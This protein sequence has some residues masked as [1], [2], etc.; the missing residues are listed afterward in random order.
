MNFNCWRTLKR[1][2]LSIYSEFT[3]N[4]GI[5]EIGSLCEGQA[6]ESIMQS[7]ERNRFSSAKEYPRC[8]LTCCLGVDSRFL[9]PTLLCTATQVLYSVFLNELM[10]ALTTI[11]F[12]GGHYTCHPSPLRRRGP[13]FFL[14]HVCTGPTRLIHSIAFIDIVLY[15][16][17]GFTYGLGIK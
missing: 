3:K 7:S 2:D 9:Y 5:R 12:I 11:H 6:E 1:Y 16:Y 10:D 17:Q 13:L 14:Y 15:I 8:C 4:S